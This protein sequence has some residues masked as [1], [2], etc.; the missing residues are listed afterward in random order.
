MKLI[1]LSAYGTEGHGRQ[2]RAGDVRFLVPVAGIYDKDMVERK[3]KPVVPDIQIEAA[4]S[5]D[6][7]H[8]YVL[9]R[10]MKEIATMPGR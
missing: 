5:I 4:A 9:D 2:F 6:A 7:T 3:R 10:A 1:G 8:D